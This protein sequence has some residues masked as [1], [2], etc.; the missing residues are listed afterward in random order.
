MLTIPVVALA[1]LFT[2]LALTSF[3]AASVARAASDKL[4]G[5]LPTSLDEATLTLQLQRSGRTAS[6]TFAAMLA[7][8]FVLASTLEASLS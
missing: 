4:D 5:N 3:Q 8:A 6:I 2:V 7:V 1:S